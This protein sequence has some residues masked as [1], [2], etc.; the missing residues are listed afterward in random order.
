MVLTPEP[1][2]SCPK[3]HLGIYKDFGCVLHTRPQVQPETVGRFEQNMI[4]SIN[5]CTFCLETNQVWVAIVKAY[6][7]ESEGAEQ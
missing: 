6:E 5:M 3:H 1:L 7:T 2:P 4:K